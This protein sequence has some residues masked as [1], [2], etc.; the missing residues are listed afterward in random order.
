MT[1]ITVIVPVRNEEAAIRGTLTALLSQAYPKEQFEVIVADGGS[2]DAT[3]AIVRELQLDHANLHLTYNPKRW[4][5]AARNLGVRH[6]QGDV[7]VIVDGHCHVP[8]RHYLQNLSDALRESG[9]ECLGRPQPLDSD[10]PSPFQQAVSAAR[11]SRL[12]H[13]PDSDIYSN[14]SKFVEPQNTAIAYRREV[15]ERIGLFDESFDACEDV[16]FNQRV[17]D[18]GFRCFFTPKLTIVYHPRTSLCGLTKQ[19]VRYGTGRARLAKK[20]PAS[21]T[22]PA[23]VPPLWLVWLVIGLVL[24]LTVRYFAWLYAASIILYASMILGGS[25]WLGRGMA[26]CVALRIPGVLLGIHF[27]FGWGFLRESLRKRQ[28][29]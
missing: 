27:G 11:S 18:A 6:M 5:S 7:A 13:N 20:H 28:I 8:D 16:E 17:F 9:A 3:V 1:S 22:L 29:E 2:E 15:F 26:P 14:E 24:S 23:L 4:S 25:V 12:G 19:L 10:D 21:L